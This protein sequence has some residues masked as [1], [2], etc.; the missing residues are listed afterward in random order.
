MQSI[1]SAFVNDN[2]SPRPPLSLSFLNTAG[3]FAHFLVIAI[4]GARIEEREI[5]THG[6][7]GGRG[8]LNAGK[9]EI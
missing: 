7:K 6:E 2:L 9:I 5:Y 1:N 4:E 3:V 8:K